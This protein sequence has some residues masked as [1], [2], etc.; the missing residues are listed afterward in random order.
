MKISGKSVLVTGAS[1]F[2]GFHLTRFLSNKASVTVV[3]RHRPILDFP[4]NVSVVEADLT[5]QDKTQSVV[6][7]AD[8]DIIFHLAAFTDVGRGVENVTAALDNI[9]MTVNLLAASGSVK[10]FVNIGTCE[11]Y[12][13]NPAP[14]REDMAP[15]PVSPYSASKTSSLLFGEVFRRNYGVPVV[16]LRP[17]LTYGPY[18]R[19]NRFVSSLIVSCIEGRDFEMSGGKQKRELNYVDDIVDGFVR[20]AEKNVVGETI[21]IG[22]GIPYSVRDIAEKIRELS[23]S[24]IDLGLG[25]LPYRENEI[26]ELFCDNTKARKLLGW[27]PKTSLEDGLTQTI[28]WYRNARSNPE[29]YAYITSP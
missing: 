9:K 1:G 28:E 18:Q 21:N 26:W 20:A 19:T 17:F 25:K 23:H 3:V 5:D 12:G 29:L 14:F 2:I 15:I 4:D 22:N 24:S 13:L 8:P 11:E 27:R 10:R 16:S 7:S 6:Y